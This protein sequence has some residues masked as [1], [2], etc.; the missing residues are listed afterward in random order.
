MMRDR[1]EILRLASEA[2]E[3]YL[4][5]TRQHEDDVADVDAAAAMLEVVVRLIRDI[6]GP[7]PVL[8]LTN[9][10]LAEQRHLIPEVNEA[11][12]ERAARA[13]IAV[14]NGNV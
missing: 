4:E 3:R 14:P 9:R 13:D 11:A 8:L 7:T 6:S 10:V 5:V 12:A 1:E 2:L